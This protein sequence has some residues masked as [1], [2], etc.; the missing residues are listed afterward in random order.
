MRLCEK[1]RTAQAITWTLSLSNG[2]KVGSYG[3]S[4]G[5]SDLMLPLT[6]GLFILLVWV[7]K[8]SESSSAISC[9][10]FSDLSKVRGAKELETIQS[11]TE[12][13]DRD[14]VCCFSSLAMRFLKVLFFSGRWELASYISTRSDCKGQL[15]TCMTYARLLLRTISLVWLHR[16]PLCLVNMKCQHWTSTNCT[17]DSEAFFFRRHTACTDAEISCKFPRMEGQKV[18][19]CRWDRNVNHDRVTCRFSDEKGSHA[20]HGG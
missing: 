7:A 15:P 6:G 16:L 18:M 13:R 8:P 11:S 19:F 5:R 20:N 17:A 2:G 3:W 1:G 10:E 9:I 14:F 4:S 12:K